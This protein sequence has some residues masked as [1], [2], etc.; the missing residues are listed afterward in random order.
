MDYESYTG[1][2][3]Q[4][5]A[6]SSPQQVA[7]EKVT[8]DVKDT[9]DPPRFSQSKYVFKI[10]E[11]VRAGTTITVTKPDGSSGGLVINDAD[12]PKT[13][14]ECTIENIQSLDVENQFKVTLVTSGNSGECKLVT[15]APFDHFDTPKF[16]FEVRATDKNYRNMYASAMVEVQI[17]DKNNHAPVFSQSSYWA[18]VSSNFPV[19]N[20]ILKVTAT[21]KDSGSF[22]EITYELLDSED[23]NR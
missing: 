12:T 19:R 6:S 21:D 11:D 23:R 18:S 3:Y 13:Q 17:Q 14:F 10:D 16:T 20:S 9:K 5:Q 22:G 15:Q 7:T 2:V 1:G 8:I 4:V